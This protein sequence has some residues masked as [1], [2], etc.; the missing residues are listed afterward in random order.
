M[1]VPKYQVRDWNFH[2]ENAG[3]RPVEHCR[4]VCM[5]NNQDGIAYQKM[6]S[7]EEGI[8]HYAVFVALILMLSRQ[9]RP[10]EGWL[11]D[12]GQEDGT[13]YTAFE[14]RLK[15]KMPEKL[16]QPALDFLCRPENT[17]TETWLYCHM[18]GEESPSGPPFIPREPYPSSKKKVPAGNKPMLGTKE[19]TNSRR[20]T[21]RFVQK[22]CTVKPRGK[23][24][25]MTTFW[26]KVKEEYG[27]DF[28]AAQKLITTM[29]DEMVK[30]GKGKKKS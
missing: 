25:E 4:W 14:I 23:K 11:T 22:Y 17:G 29:G 28:K 27:K 2:F 6:I 24:S 10:R 3:S 7:T 18:E 12:N 20:A 1:P 19:W 26:A 8:Q 13:P 15:T 30:A 21:A 5:P 9:E 16:I